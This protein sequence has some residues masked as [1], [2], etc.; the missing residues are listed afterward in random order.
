MARFLRNQNEPS[1]ALD[2]QGPYKYRNCNAHR[3]HCGWTGCRTYGSSLLYARVWTSDVPSKPNRLAGHG[4]PSIVVRRNI[5]RVTYST[6]V[7]ADVSDVC[8]FL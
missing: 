7:Q 4:S 3:N 6:M 5:I 2:S 8:A 1:E